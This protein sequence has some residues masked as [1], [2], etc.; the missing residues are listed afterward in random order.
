MDRVQEG[1]KGH[2]SDPF[3][4]LLSASRRAKFVFVEAAK[5]ALRTQSGEIQPTSRLPRLINT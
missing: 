1:K 2:G 5:R 4:R 3:R